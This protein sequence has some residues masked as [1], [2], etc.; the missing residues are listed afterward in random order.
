MY[1]Q[2]QI[3]SMSKDITSTTSEGQ[4]RSDHGSR[5]VSSSFQ[6]PYKNLNPQNIKLGWENSFTIRQFYSV[7]RISYRLRSSTITNSIM[8]KHEAIITS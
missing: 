4:N 5:N 1:Q 2:K 3:T 7:L 8:K 6:E